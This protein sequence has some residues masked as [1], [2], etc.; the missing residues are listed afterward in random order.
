MRAA[1]EAR[2]V[3]L[4]SEF[5][6]ERT[7]RARLCLVQ[8]ATPQT[9]YLI[10]PL[11]VDPSP[12]AELI[13]DPSIE[14]VVHA[15][16]QD[17]EIIYEAFGSVPAAVYDVQLAAGF[18]GYGASLPYGRLVEATLGR[19]LPK[20]ETYSDWCR[21]PLTRPQL[22]YAA[23]DV[24]Y[25]VE[26]AD[27]LKARIE[28]LARSDWVAEEMARLSDPAAY[29]SDPAEAWRRVAGRGSLSPQQ[30]TALRELARWRE[31]TAARRDLPRGWV[32]KDPTLVEIARRRPRSIEDLQKIR[33][34]NEREA[35][36]SGREIL[37]VL[38]AARRSPPMRVKAPPPKQA[39]ARA[40]LL[41]GLAD[42]VVR[43][44][45]E[46]AGIA[47]ELVSTRGELESL[48]IDL[49]SNAGAA[50]ESHRLL[51]GWRWELAGKAV[52]DLVAG[53]I[54]VRAM[55]KPPWVQEVGL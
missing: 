22:D 2:R 32:V 52:E 40:R 25:L 15:G 9:A 38:D 33:G 24:R 7:Y 55:N 12:V 27:L 35:N 1:R 41:S 50:R 39:Q 19:T 14:V 20:G 21:R 48:I 3:G 45:C 47:T 36:R 29:G 10:D 28:E 8:I 26:I 42:A 53:R 34:M 11:E 49:V 51:A 46:A 54:A 17:F 31:E 37:A 30:S 13:A 43:A 18:A 23:A 6:R 16:K 4:D 44:R 5:L